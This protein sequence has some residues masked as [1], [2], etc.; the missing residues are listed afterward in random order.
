MTNIP[1]GV[2]F[3]NMTL[4]SCFSQDGIDIMYVRA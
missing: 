1:N 4:K 2:A 3:G